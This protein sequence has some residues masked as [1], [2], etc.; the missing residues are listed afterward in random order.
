MDKLYGDAVLTLVAAAGKDADTG[1]PGVKPGTRWRGQYWENVGDLKIYV[2]LPLLRESLESFHTANRN[3]KQIH[4]NND[5]ETNRNRWSTRGWTYQDGLLSRKCL[6][7]TP[8]QVFWICCKETNCESIAEAL[9]H[10]REMAD[11]PAYN[12]IFCSSQLERNMQDSKD[13]FHS[14]TSCH[15]FEVVNAHTARNLSFDSDRLNAFAGIVNAMQTSCGSSF[16]F[17]LPEDILD[18]SLLWVPT[19]RHGLNIRHSQF[20]SWSWASW[21]GCVDYYVFNS[22]RP[23]TD[24]QIHITQTAASIRQHISY[25]KFTKD[26]KAKKVKQ[27]NVR[28]PPSVEEEYGLVTE[29]RGLGYNIHPGKHG[30]GACLY[31]VKDENPLEPTLDAWSE[32]L[33][34]LQPTE[35]RFLPFLVMLTGIFTLRIVLVESESGYCCRRC[36]VVTQEKDWSRS[37]ELDECVFVDDARDV[38]RLEGK[39]CDFLTLSTCHSE[40][41]EDLVINIMLV[42]RLSDGTMSRLGI[43]YIRRPTWDQ[44]KPED[45]W[46]LLR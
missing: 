1:L 29:D 18:F 42:D 40:T 12:D 9:D 34:D 20:P 25:W 35:S 37:N 7:F 45:E 8:W 33:A 44:A 13:A 6:I 39:R 41:S 36:R 15:Y 28:Y 10:Q 4:V 43:G 46:V 16:L 24:Y 17:G 22:V 32:A 14:G 30:S 11:T 38:P 27:K 21:P 2:S 26:R 5:H 31:Q 23:R 19:S 3:G